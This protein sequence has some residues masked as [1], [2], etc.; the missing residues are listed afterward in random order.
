MAAGDFPWMTSGQ[1]TV[2]AQQCKDEARR[3]LP[4]AQ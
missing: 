4:P 2:A 1:H 3:A